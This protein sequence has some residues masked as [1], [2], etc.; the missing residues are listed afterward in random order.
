VFLDRRVTIPFLI[1]GRTDGR[2]TAPP[3]GEGSH[4]KT[5][6]SEAAFRQA[7]T[8]SVDHDAADNR[9]RPT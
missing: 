3:G 1:G 9:N 8:L 2:R 5:T 6:V 4:H 7:A